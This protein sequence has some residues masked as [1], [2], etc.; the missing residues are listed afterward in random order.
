[1]MGWTLGDFRRK[2]ISKDAPGGEGVPVP[3]GEMSAVEP[4]TYEGWAQLGWVVE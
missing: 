3:C 2:G 1:M 4:G